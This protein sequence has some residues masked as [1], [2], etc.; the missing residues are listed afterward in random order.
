ME[1]AV[2]ASLNTIRDM[3]VNSGQERLL[4]MAK[5]HK[6]LGR[7]VR[8]SFCCCILA[9]LACTSSLRAQGYKIAVSGLDAPSLQ[10]LGFLSQNAF[11]DSTQA[12]AALGQT[13]GKLHLQ[14]YFLAAFTRLA[15]NDTL[16][17]GELSS[18]NK[19]SWLIKDRRQKADFGPST[20]HLQKEL[21]QYVNQGYPF[22]SVSFDSAS[23]VDNTLQVSIV[24]E[25]GPYILFDSLMVKGAVKT[26][27]TFLQNYLFVR[28]STPYSERQ[29]R[30]I[31]FR[32]NN[33]G[34]MS[35]TS[36]PTVSFYSGRSLVFLEIEEL[37]VNKIDGVL[38]FLPQQNVNSGKLLL[39][40]QLEAELY[41]L[42]GTGK[43]LAVNWQ[44]YNSASQVLQATYDHPVIL[45]SPIDFD[46]AFAQLK[47]DSAF[48]T[49]TTQA[50][51]SIPIQHSWEFGVGVSFLRNNLLDISGITSAEQ[52][53]NA[54]S[55]SNQYS[56]RASFSSLDQAV[57]P[58]RGVRA[59]LAVSTGQKEIIKNNSLG[60]ELYV[61]LI[62][63]TNQSSAN[64][65][66]ENYAKPTGRSVLF[67][68][69]RSY[70]LFNPQL[71]QND[72]FRIGGLRHLRGFNENEFY[73]QY[74]T[75]LAA[76]WRLVLEKESYL[77]SFVDQA[78]ISSQNNQ[79]LYALGFGG[80]MALKVN[81]G[82]FRLMIAL[83]A[84]EGQRLDPTQPKIHFGFESRF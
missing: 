4:Y 77:V 14:G 46:G 30:G 38:G 37:Q 73:A 47:Q 12:A 32:V 67:Q 71:F 74:Y 21:Q 50:G 78:V 82:V 13:I 3:D 76:E 11:Q 9:A 80:G 28:K 63:N 53:T 36:N 72:L 18:G 79:W 61:D 35:L 65:S 25:K 55:R 84:A 43:H 24:S 83:G 39:T 5:L 20:E 52:L 68:H 75:S 34:F 15:W 7:I 6:T 69:L 58:T 48:V 40:G 81:N 26:R 62:L 23:L 33:S 59:S 70:A 66:F 29:V 45:G 44:N 16:V 54:D 10:A 1:V 42:F 56:L 19:M 64:F 57:F 27:N 49:R 22:A 2:V 17:S 51:F 41:N 31:P 60:E 8:F